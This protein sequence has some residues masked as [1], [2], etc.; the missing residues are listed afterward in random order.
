M[1]VYTSANFA[2]LVINHAR[3]IYVDLVEHLNQQRLGDLTFKLTYLPR[4]RLQ[5]K[6]EQGSMDG[7]VIGM[8][9]QWLDDVGQKK[10]LW[11]APF[12]VDRFVLV[13]RT[14]SGIDPNAAVSV[15]GRS[16]GLVLGYVYPGIDEW[17][18]RYGLVRNDAL[19]EDINLEKLRLGRVDC[20][21]VAESVARYYLKTH[22]LSDQFQLADLPGQQTERRFLIPHS[23]AAVYDKLAPVIRRL[24]DDPVWQR[25]A[26]KYQ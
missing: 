3:G 17:I 2:P 5:M 7:I 13:S 1:N 16:I 11:T 24:K 20:V 14:G 8:M 23:K 25:S 4:K 22:A 6:L 12:A 19:S 26:S 9:P 21:A 15:S 18:A 10:Y